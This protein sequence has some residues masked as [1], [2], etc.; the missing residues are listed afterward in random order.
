MFMTKDTT[1]SISAIGGALVAL[2]AEMDLLIK[3]E[4]RIEAQL[5]AVKSK[6]AACYTAVHKIIRTSSLK[7]LHDPQ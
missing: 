7:E 1:V 6:K 4:K 3:E 5:K 2:E